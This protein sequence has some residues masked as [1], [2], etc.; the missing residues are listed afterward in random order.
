L[1]FIFGLPPP[2]LLPPPIDAWLC[3][4]V[5][6]SVAEHTRPLCDINNPTKGR[7]EGRRGGK[8]GRRR[9]KRFYQ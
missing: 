5:L 2:P 4:L 9:C 1:S 7:E 6:G 3:N 8:R